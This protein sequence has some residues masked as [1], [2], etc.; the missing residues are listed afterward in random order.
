M[1]RCQLANKGENWK[2]LRGKEDVDLTVTSESH[3]T[4]YLTLQER[5]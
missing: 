5:S 4:E 3:K 1:A 2:G